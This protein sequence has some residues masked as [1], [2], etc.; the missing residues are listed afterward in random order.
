MFLVHQDEC[1]YPILDSARYYIWVPLNCQDVW[2]SENLDSLRLIP[3]FFGVLLNVSALSFNFI[4]ATK[5]NYDYISENIFHY[6]ISGTESRWTK[7]DPIPRP[8]PYRLKHLF[9]ESETLLKFAL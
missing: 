9:L 2:F 7:N 4:G 1:G 5:N 3:M 6:L 8:T